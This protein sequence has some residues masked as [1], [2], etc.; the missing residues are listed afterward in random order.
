MNIFSDACV[1]LKYGAGTVSFCLESDHSSYA[2]T[3]V[4]LPFDAFVA[5]QA[6]F[7][8]EVEGMQ[9]AH[10]QWLALQ[11]VDAPASERTAPSTPAKEPLG[12]KIG[13]VSVG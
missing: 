1:R 5:M 2:G 4:H 3:T 9:D 6:A 13:S 10:R 11:A 8:S 12:V 7:A